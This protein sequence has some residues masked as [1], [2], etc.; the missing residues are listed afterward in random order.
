MT[1]IHGLR[2]VTCEIFFSR[3]E[4]YHSENIFLID[5]DVE[6]LLFRLD[7]INTGKLTFLEI[8]S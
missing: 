3:I 4:L 8:T 2:A 7:Y 5:K 1:G 6:N